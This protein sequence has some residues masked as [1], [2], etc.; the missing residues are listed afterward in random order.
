VLGLPE[1]RLVR[2]RGEGLDPLE[3]GDAVHLE[4][5]RADD[6]WRAAYPDATP[7]NVELVASFVANWRGSPLAARV[8]ALD[9][10]RREVP[11]AFEVDGVLF[12]GRLD[13]CGEQAPG[14]L[15]VVDYK[16]NRLGEQAAEDVVESAYRTQITT[17]ALAGL[18]SG[19]QRVD[20]AYAFLE[21]P[22]G[23]VERSFTAADA[24]ALEGELAQAIADIRAARFRARPG[25]YCEDCPALNLL[26]AG[27]ALEWEEA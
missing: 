6:R 20:I 19:A 8:Q 15:L 24:E 21:R 18:R 22:D 2:E 1:R 7:E 5:E 12:R 25:P 14:H 3:L 26:C 13:I 10:C 4:L 23:V 27:P 16:T 11:F 17:Y 9:R